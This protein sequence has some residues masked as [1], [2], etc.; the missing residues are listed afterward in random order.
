M[1]TIVNALHKWLN[2]CTV[3]MFIHIVDVFIYHDADNTQ[4]CCTINNAVVVLYQ[5]HIY[6]L[7]MDDNDSKYCYQVN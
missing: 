6:L 1:N 4:K 7:G 2:V 5:S 3:N